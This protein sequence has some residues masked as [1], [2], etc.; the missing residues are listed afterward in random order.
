LKVAVATSSFVLSLNDTAAAWIYMN[1]GAVLPLI[2]VPSVAGIM[3]GTR[4]GVRV[5]SRA[6]SR[7]VKLVVVSILFAA[8]IR[9][10]LGGLGVL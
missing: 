6:K 1:R 9:A 8:G 10:L 4:I 2:T 7:I 3:I 5:L